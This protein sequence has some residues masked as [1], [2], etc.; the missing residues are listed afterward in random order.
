MVKMFLDQSV[1]FK[2]F[3]NHKLSPRL[4]LYP[5][6]SRIEPL[7]HPSSEESRVESIFENGLYLTE[8]HP[9][10]WYLRDIGLSY[11]RIYSDDMH[12]RSSRPLDVFPEIL[13]E[14]SSYRP[15][16]W[17]FSVDISANDNNRWE[18]FESL[19]AL[20][21][22]SGGFK[23]AKAQKPVQIVSKMEYSNLTRYKVVQGT[24]VSSF[25][26]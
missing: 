4:N 22:T 2:L 9:R 21:P 17:Q 13:R 6:S 15:Q 18:T 11:R 3:W 5:M 16:G 14:R 24:F 25:V 10:T 7:W 23:R 8:L 12:R 19:S 26:A 20:S 1:A